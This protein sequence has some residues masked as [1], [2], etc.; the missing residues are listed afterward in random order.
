MKRYIAIML[1]LLLLAGCKAEVG[2]PGAAYPTE[3]RSS[4]STAEAIPP[5][6]SV[7]PDHPAGPEP[8]EP[9]PASNLGLT[10]A[11]EPDWEGI[12]VEL[13]PEDI[14]RIRSDLM[15][16]TLSPEEL[17]PLVREAMGHPVEYRVK[18]NGDDQIWSLHLTLRVGGDWRDGETTLYAGLEEDL[19]G[20]SLPDKFFWV[21]DAALYRPVRTSMDT[22]PDIDQ[23]AYEDYGD[24]IRAHYDR[25]M[26]QR[27]QQAE[28]GLPGDPGWTASGWEL[29]VLRL[30]A[31]REDLGVW[32]YDLRA[33]N[34][35]DPLELAPYR[36]AGG[37]YVDSRLAIHGWDWKYTYLAVVDGETVGVFYLT[38][39]LDMDQFTTRQ[40]F[41][42]MVAEESV[43]G[44]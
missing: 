7:G 8:P 27:N 23:A 5:V 1:A 4:C 21:E 13:Q 16:Q 11:S 31:E 43:A 17:A 32:V 29:H 30:A 42:D 2:A 35:L 26:A 28:E 22:P 37:A 15:D 19:V 3:A 14:L 20:I 12:L 36:V 44:G 10:P 24:F 18:E 41:L 34:Y 38:E 9:F 6:E 40:E 25:D 33:V 39:E